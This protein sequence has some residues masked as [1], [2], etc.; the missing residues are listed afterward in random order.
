MGNL[1]GIAFKL[2]KF[3]KMI[4]CDSA[5][6]STVTGVAQDVRGGKGKR[7]VTVLDTQR[8]HDACKEIGKELD[9]T[10]R[11][12]NL[13]I[14]GIDL[15][16]SKGKYLCVNEL[17]LEI[18]GETTPCYRMDEQCEGLK[19]ALIPEWRGGVCCRVI[20]GGEIKIGDTITITNDDPAHRSNFTRWMVNCSDDIRKMKRKSSKLLGLSK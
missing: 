6:V 17:V 10:I 16:Q 4:V 8:Y 2:E 9:W 14:E 7:Q 1:T 3:G 19:T 20:R 5:N 15:F 18:T 13:L 12:A 11:R